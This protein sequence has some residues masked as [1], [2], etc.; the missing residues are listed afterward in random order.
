MAHQMIAVRD[1]S[2]VCQHTTHDISRMPAAML[3]R[4]LTFQP[5]VPV[6]E[7]VLVRNLKTFLVEF[8]KVS[9]V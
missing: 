1:F 3:V 2:D 7:I 4:F 6:V 8:S 5:V 9:V